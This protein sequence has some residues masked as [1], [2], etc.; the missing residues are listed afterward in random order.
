M[1]DVVEFTPINIFLPFQFVIKNKNLELSWKSLI[2]PFSFWKTFHIKVWLVIFFCTLVAGILIFIILSY[3]KSPEDNNKDWNKKRFVWF[4]FGSYL[5]QGIDFKVVKRSS[6]RVA[7]VF[8]ILPV[9]IIC[10]AYGGTLTS[11]MI[12]KEKQPLPKTF[13]EL[14]SAVQKGEFTCTAPDLPYVM[15]FFKN[16]KLS[17]LKI[18]YEEILSND[19]IDTYDLFMNGN[20]ESFDYTR[21]AY[22]YNMGFMKISDFETAMDV[23]ASDDVLFSMPSAFVMRKGFPHK[24]YF[25]NIMYNIFE[26]GVQDHDTE[27]DT[28][29]NPLTKHIK[30][31]VSM[32]KE[33]KSNVDPLVLRHFY[34]AFA[35]LV[36]G[37]LL[38]FACFLVE[39]IIGKT[40]KRFQI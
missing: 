15:N 40:M 28:W 27:V 11:F 24:E 3:D 19:I 4:L 13:E 36:I 25:N 7:L 14:A 1:S 5:N 10:W 38:S 39:L 31:R 21:V 12:T 8:W 32:S 16:S 2:S 22:I 37:Y 30:E 33:T 26:S 34:G 9:L 35:I 20:D 17:Y 6:S 18:L 23:T 29:N